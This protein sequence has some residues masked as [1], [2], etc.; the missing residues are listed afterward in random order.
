[1]LYSTNTI[2]IGS[3]FLT[4]HLP[5]FILPQRL[6]CITSLELAWELLLHS[7]FDPLAEHGKD[8]PAYNALVATVGSAFPSLTKLYISL[9]TLSCLSDAFDQKYESDEQKILH[10][11]DEM[12]RKLGAQLQECQIAPPR[13]LY[14]ALAAKAKRRGALIERERPG[15]FRWERFWRPVVEEHGEQSGDHLGYWVR[16]GIENTPIYESTLL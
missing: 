9:D 8:E 11:M 15:T 5:L 7:P 14:E 16:Q 1:M 13:S 4:R 12:V 6:A 3:A 2:H 10:P